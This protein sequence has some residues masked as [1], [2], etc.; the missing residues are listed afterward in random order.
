MARRLGKKKT[1]AE[2]IRFFR[3]LL[4][5]QYFSDPRVSRTYFSADNGLINHHPFGRLLLPSDET[6]THS[7]FL[8]CAAKRSKERKEEKEK[9]QK[10][11]ALF[12]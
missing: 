2:I 10:G 6:S 12:S 1:I 9:I 5:W 8:V 7:T 3:R 11:L 4:F